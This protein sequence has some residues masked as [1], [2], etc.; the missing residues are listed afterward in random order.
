MDN[1]KLQEAMQSYVKDQSKDNLLMVLNQLRNARL[2]V[3][4]VFQKGQIYQLLPMLHQ[5]QS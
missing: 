4:S 5:E 3:P 2:F 1:L